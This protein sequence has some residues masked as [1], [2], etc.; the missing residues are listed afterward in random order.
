MV[1]SI[2]IRPGARVSSSLN[3]GI[4]PPA[5]TTLLVLDRV[6]AGALAECEAVVD[7][8]AE[9]LIVHRAEDGGVR[10]WL[11]IC[12]HAGRRLDWAPGR[13]LQGKDGS[14]INVFGP[15]TDPLDPEIK[16]AVEAAL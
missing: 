6:A 2:G 14:L 9:S 3:D 16:A 8:E 5:A 12:P 1:A 13:F 4:A 7:G 11:N 15:R 10:A